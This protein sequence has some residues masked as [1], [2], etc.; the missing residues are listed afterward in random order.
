CMSDYDDVVAR[1][2]AL[3]DEVDGCTFYDELFPDNEVTGESHSDYS[4]PNA[5]YLYRDTSGER[6]RQ[7]R[8]IMLADTWEEDYFEYVDGNPLA[9]CSGLTYRG[10]VN[11]FDNAQRMNA[12][13]F[14]LDAVGDKQLQTLLI[15]RFGK[16]S[17]QIRSM[18]MPTYIV[19]SGTGLHV[20]YFLDEPLDLYPGIKMQL[21]ALKH[22]LTYKLWDPISTS[23]LESIQYQPVSQSF[24]MIGS[25]NEK[26]GNIVRAFRTGDAVSLET[27]NEYT[28][29]PENRVSL[30]KRNIPGKT[31]I[32]VAKKKW[33]GWYEERIVQR[34]PSSGRWDISGKVHGNDP[35]ALY[36]WF[37]RFTP[38]IQGGHRYFF[39]MCCV[40]YASKCNVPYS[41][42]VE[43]LKQVYER[44][45]HVDHGGDEL[46]ERDMRSALK[47]YKRDY[48]NIRLDDIE[49][50]TDLR[51]PRNKRNGRTQEKHLAGARAIRDI[52]N[53][54][55]RDGNGRHDKADEVLLWRLHHPEG[56]KAACIRDLGLS[57]PTVYKWWNYEDTQVDLEFMRDWRKD[58]PGKTMEDCE[59][60]TRLPHDYVKR[61]WGLID[62]AIEIVRKV[63][64]DENLGTLSKV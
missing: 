32:E 61:V 22:D 62:E 7:R 50:M 29:K 53:E 64:G 21:K 36:H 37:L 49:K 30:T 42:L 48:Y 20:Y 56:K 5:I 60:A 26:Y 14:D 33:P 24:R 27:L 1:L 52:N 6:V 23:R 44:L 4:K 16:P 54:N 10:R 17:D 12:L 34:K 18:P 46:T 47:A 59:K 3:Y 45:R 35:Y 13:I 43:D 2:S 55:W 58:N 38:Q 8:R 19:A 63:N 40:I 51:I 11:K 9:L 39:M 57:K 41:Q 28:I 25:R 15:T 31:R